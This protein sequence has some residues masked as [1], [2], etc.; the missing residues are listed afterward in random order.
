MRR[1]SRVRAFSRAAARCSSASASSAL[2]KRAAA[3]LGVPTTSLSVKSGV[4]S[5]GGKTVTYGQLIGDKLFNTSITGFNVAGTA[6]TPARAVAGGPGT[7]PVGSYTMV[8]QR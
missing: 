7:K 4:V 2:L 5:G 3:N 6:T 8:G 1:S